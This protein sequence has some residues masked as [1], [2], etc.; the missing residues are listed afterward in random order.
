MKKLIVIFGALGLSISGLNGALMAIPALNPSNQTVSQEFI[1]KDIMGDISNSELL[2]SNIYPLLNS[3]KKPSKVKTNSGFKMLKKFQNFT[4]K[5]YKEFKADAKSLVKNGK[6]IKPIE[7]TVVNKIVATE[8]IIGKKIIPPKAIETGLD[9][10]EKIS[11]IGIKDIVKRNHGIKNF[12]TKKSNK[13]KKVVFKIF[14]KKDVVKN[15][16]IFLETHGKNIKTGI[17]KGPRILGQVVGQFTN[18]LV[19]SLFGLAPGSIRI[20]LGSAIIGAVGYYAYNHPDEA[21]SFASSVFDTTKNTASST[22]QFLKT[23]WPF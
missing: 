19:C 21:K 18:G 6:K 13:V 4:K 15:F 7:K 10:V 8:K 16:K 17:K 23:W 9:K 11:E 3:D 2:S 22:V 1:I 20:A 14:P 5:V 12:F